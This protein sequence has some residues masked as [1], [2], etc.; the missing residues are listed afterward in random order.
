[1]VNRS[2]YQLQ[3]IKI[4]VTDDGFNIGCLGEV[5]GTCLTIVSDLDV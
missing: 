3:I 5:E 2:R 1:M 4:E